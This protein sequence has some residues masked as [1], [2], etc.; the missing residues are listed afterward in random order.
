MRWNRAREGCLV[1]EATWRIDGAEHDLQQVNRAAGLKSV[2]VRRDAAH[3][4]H[5]DGAANH[6]V[7]PA[8][9]EIRPWHIEGDGFFERDM[10]QLGGDTADGISGHAAPLGYRIGCVFRR[11]V[12]LR[13]ELEGGCDR[14]PV[15]KRK[16]PHQRARGVVIGGGSGSLFMRV[17]YQR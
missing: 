12:A 2:C 5:G 9:G 3:R 4:V 15:G 13:N 11:E 14:A 16:A 7:M 10:R 8:T 1:T 17:P 6:F